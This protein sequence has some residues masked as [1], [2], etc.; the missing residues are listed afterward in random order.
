MSQLNW[1]VALI[2]LALAAPPLAAAQNAATVIVERVEIQEITETA[3][4]IG[5][6]VA[7]VEAEVATRRDG[8][9]EAVLF[10][11]GDRVVK[12]QALARLDDQLVRIQLRNADAALNAARAGV[13][14]AEA[15]VKLSE[16]AFARQ[17][18]LKGSTAFSGSSFE[19]AEQR[20]AEAR[21]ELA[22]AQALV[23]VAEAA[24]ARAEYDARHS[25]I[26]APFD[27]IAIARSAQP[28]QYISLGGAVA[29][30]LDT[31]NLEIEADVPVD[32]LAGL[33]AG[34][35]LEAI[36]ANDRVVEATV[37]TLLPVES[38]STRTRPVRLNIDVSKIPGYL[39]AAGKSVTLQVPVSEPRQA[40]MVPKDALVQ[41]LSG[42]WIVFVAEDGKASPRPVSIGQ[43]N[44]DRL[45][46]LS[47]LAPGE[48]VVVRGNERLRPGQPIT[49][50]IKEAGPDAG[51]SGSTVP[52]QPAASEPAAAADEKTMAPASNA[53]VTGAPE[54]R[55]AARSNS[56]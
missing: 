4:V 2:A 48:L 3:P 40:L 24:F 43:A 36:V 16:Q 19:D 46:V 39:V 37:R 55:P 45:E 14:V 32:L 13:S 15:R 5:Q 33:D 9:V 47:G 50:E 11:I 31:A 49:A 42:A 29:K 23:A 35:V 7:T 34:R 26:R 22:R 6:L 27:G 12:G 41:S 54:P 52:E 53:E 51:A 1:S 44:R 10:D 56:G 8:I 28:G 25:V 21:S 18:R 17:S 30:L 38:V 20:A